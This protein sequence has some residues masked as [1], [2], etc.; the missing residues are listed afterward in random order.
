MTNSNHPPFPYN[1]S[2]ENCC[3][4]GKVAGIEIVELEWCKNEE[5][6]SQGV[7]NHP[8]NF[9]SYDEDVIAASNLRSFQKKWDEFFMEFMDMAQNEMPFPDE[10]ENDVDTLDE[11][12]IWFT[13]QVIRNLDGTSG[14][15]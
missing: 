4:L 1:C 13:M 6:I 2:D 7:P 12:R 8:K 9:H 5:C 3:N 10:Y 14:I 15:R 11:F